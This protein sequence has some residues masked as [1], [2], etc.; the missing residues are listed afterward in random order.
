[1]SEQIL[2]T[3]GKFKK[4]T[5][6][7]DLQNDK[8]NFIN[9]KKVLLSYLI[10]ETQYKSN[11]IK[12]NESDMDNLIKK[13]I[14]Y[15]IINKEK[16]KF[17]I[18]TCSFIGFMSKFG[19]SYRFLNEE[20]QKKLLSL[21]LTY[22][23]FKKMVLNIYDEYINTMKKMWP[24][25]LEICYEERGFISYC[26]FYRKLE[27][28][29]DNFMYII[30]DYF[31]LKKGESLYGYFRDN[32]LFDTIRKKVEN[33]YPIYKEKYGMNR[34]L[35]KILSYIDPQ[36]ND[37]ANEITRNLLNNYYNNKNK[38]KNEDKDEYIPL[39]HKED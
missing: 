28:Q 19:L 4:F 37:Y 38:D 15:N 23:S 22:D 25:E 31:L 36:G 1:M 16:L 5:K 30:R 13:N 35:E 2:V 9:A 3:F 33:L 12:E 20:V 39:K 34:Y 11:L 7:E 17:D 29:K 24:I 10:Y 14:S 8:I 27:I 26:H 32:D 6:E 18:N 21:E